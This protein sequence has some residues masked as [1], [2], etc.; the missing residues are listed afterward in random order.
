MR[1]PSGGRIRGGSKMSE[2]KFMENE[3]KKLEREYHVRI[4]RARY[5]FTVNRQGGRQEFLGQFLD[6]KEAE[7]WLSWES[8]EYD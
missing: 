5:G 7:D 4:R 6:L 8:G 2:E 3:I 1:C